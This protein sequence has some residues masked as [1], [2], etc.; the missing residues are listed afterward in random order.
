MP[1]LNAQFC[2]EF[3]AALEKS[4]KAPVERSRVVGVDGQSACA[5]YLPK[6]TSAMALVPLPP[7][8]VYIEVKGTKRSEATLQNVLDSWR[9][10]P[11][12]TMATPQF[13]VTIPPGY[14]PNRL[15]E[16]AS[17]SLA[18][19]RKVRVGDFLGSAVF[20]PTDRGIGRLDANTCEDI[21]T[22]MAESTKMKVGRV[23]LVT[24]L[25]GTA[26]QVDARDLKQ[27][28]RVAEFFVLNAPFGA[29]V[30]TCNRDERDNEAL[31]GCKAAMESL[32]FKKG[33]GGGNNKNSI[34]LD[35]PA[36]KDRPKQKT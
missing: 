35:E 18:L 23:Q 12:T 34:D 1:A 22:G 32:Q 13:E 9:Y 7:G 27:A 19:I 17:N 8:A 36:P 33:G 20:I 11:V 10:E 30:V 25:G 29:L 16:V 31:V 24:V 2:Q 26:C 15:V 28:H 21:G 4:I 6:T 14:A 3:S 5:L